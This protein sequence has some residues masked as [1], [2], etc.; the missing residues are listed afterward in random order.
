MTRLNSLR[1]NSFII[2]YTYKTSRVIVKHFCPPPGRPRTVGE[3]A[4]AAPRHGGAGALCIDGNQIMH[5][6][7][8]NAERRVLILVL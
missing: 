2:L 3:T 4:T 8:W 5:V 7:D 6:M 1:L